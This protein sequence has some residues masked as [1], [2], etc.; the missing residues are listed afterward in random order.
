MVAGRELSGFA[1]IELIARVS[2]SGQPT[3]QSGDW[4]GV[5]RVRPAENSSVV[6]VI[7]EQVP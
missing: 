1:E 2:L 7:D 4:F 6:L 3:Q 5:Q